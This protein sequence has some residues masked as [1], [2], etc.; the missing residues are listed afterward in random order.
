MATIDKRSKS[1]WRA[2]V[3]VPGFGL[4]TR[5]F[6]TK[7]EAEKWARF[8]EATLRSGLDEATDLQAEPTLGEALEMYAEQ[9]TPKK[10]YRRHAE[11]L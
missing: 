7:V 4:K 2:R 5:S 11:P 1:G 3:R 8:T 9:E 6:K 10:A